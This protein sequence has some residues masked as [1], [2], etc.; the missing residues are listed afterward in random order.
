MS[1]TVTRTQAVQEPPRYQVI[2]LVAQPVLP[3]PSVPSVDPILDCLQDMLEEGFVSQRDLA[4]IIENYKSLP[5]EDGFGKAVLLC[6]VIS[7]MVQVQI[8]MEQSEQILSHLYDCEDRLMK[9][10]QDLLI[11]DIDAEDFLAQYDNRCVQMED[12]LAKQQKISNC[13][14]LS[15]QKMNASAEEVK[16]NIDASYFE[17]SGRIA[18]FAQFKSQMT[19]EQHRK[20]TELA[21]RVKNAHQQTMSHAESIDQLEERLKQDLLACNQLTQGLR[22]LMEKMHKK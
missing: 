5:A 15:I 1:Y 17:L 3:I 4:L 14:R 22:P 6:R 7:K 12:D 13:S 8:Q 10:L 20:V 2:H 19:E 18:R 9:L 11:K 21:Q 16:Q